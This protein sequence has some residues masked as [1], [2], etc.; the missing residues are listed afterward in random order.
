MIFFLKKTNIYVYIYIYIYIYILGVSGRDADRGTW[1]EQ[2]GR[3]A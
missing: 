1:H 3:L 2:H